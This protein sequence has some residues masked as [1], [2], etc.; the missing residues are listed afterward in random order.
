MKLGALGL[1]YEP[2]DIDGLFTVL[3]IRFD[4]GGRQIST[5]VFPE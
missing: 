5:H 1:D 4:A 3:E 2:R